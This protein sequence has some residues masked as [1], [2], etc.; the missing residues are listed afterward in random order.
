MEE[1]LGIPPVVDTP[2]IPATRFIRALIEKYAYRGHL[3]F[4]I[5]NGISFYLH[6]NGK[7]ISATEFQ[8]MI[9][10]LITENEKYKN[11]SMW[12][13]FCSELVLSFGIGNLLHRL[14]IP[15]DPISSTILRQRISGWGIEGVD[16][17]GSLFPAGLH[18]DDIVPRIL[19]D[20]SVPALQIP[21]ATDI[22]SARVKSDQKNYISKLHVLSS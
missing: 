1:I 8:D 19:F 4:L 16:D 20:R 21:D 10:P 17:L 22:Q 2:H 6:K 5:S 15:T 3:T 13:M 11:S 14:G 7:Y 18:K 12:Y 9:S